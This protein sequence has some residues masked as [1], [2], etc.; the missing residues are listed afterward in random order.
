[1]LTDPKE[2]QSCR[3]QCVHYST[4][5]HSPQ[6]TYSVLTYTAVSA[7]VCR[8]VYQNV[9]SPPPSI[10]EFNYGAK[11]LNIYGYIRPLRKWICSDEA[12]QLTMILLTCPQNLLQWCG[13]LSDN[14]Y[15]DMLPE[16][17]Q[18]WGRT[19]DNGYAEMPMDLLQSCGTTSDND[20][21]NLLTELPPQILP[22]SF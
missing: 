16:L 20:Y 7:W 17:L 12:E 18:S 11:G 22:L 15:A 14:D 4:I 19:C 2:D 1:M 10:Y 21:G 5:L 13:R 3:P 6:L 8:Q 9:P